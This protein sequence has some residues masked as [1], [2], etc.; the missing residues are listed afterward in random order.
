MRTRTRFVILFAVIGVAVMTSGVA[1]LYD[2]AGQ[3]LM[4]PE[5]AEAE[6]LLGKAVRITVDDSL[7]LDERVS[8]V[9]DPLITARALLARSRLFSKDSIVQ[10]SLRMAAVL[11]TIL[12]AGSAAFIVL[13]RFASRG[14]EEIA[15][16][17][18]RARKD[19]SARIQALKDPD[20]DSV[21][22]E[23]NALLDL[24]AEQERRLAEAARL[25]GWREVASFLAHQIKN[26][27]AAIKLAAQNTRLSLDG[28]DSAERVSTAKNCSDIVV[29][30]SNRL[31]ALVSRFCDLAPIGL[32][33]YNKGT[34]ADLGESLR[35]CAERASS[36][37]AAVS[38]TGADD[39]C[40][41]SADQALL[42][43]ALWNLYNNSIEAC[44]PDPASI[45]VS[46]ERTGAYYCVSITDSGRSIDPSAIADLGWKR[47]TTK[48]G[49]TGMGLVFVRRII[50]VFGGDVVFF[51]SESGGLGVRIKLPLGD[52]A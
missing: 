30:E 27:L 32:E 7:T 41:V 44:E 45:A 39:P 8:S 18:A 52:T 40:I 20:L 12:L 37:S 17:V 50:A 47:K 16:A 4:K 13:S 26:P 28:C 22:R 3:N 46:V 21:G 11:G 24:T 35:R 33:A 49:G 31:G 6:L 19:P 2:V 15:A 36:R 29:T 5:L 9:A 34:S 25:E 48:T 42:E 23:L 10:L 38:I 51:I 1:M 43:Q 14:L